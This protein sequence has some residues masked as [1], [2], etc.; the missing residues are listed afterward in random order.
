[1]KSTFTGYQGTELLGAKVI[2]LIKIDNEVESEVEKLSAG[3]QGEVVL[4]R[5][6]FYAE[7]AARLV[8]LGCWRMNRYSP[9][10]RTHSRR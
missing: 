2:A 5:T 9:R 7:S 3:E 10:C 4:D 8:I 6:P 1:M